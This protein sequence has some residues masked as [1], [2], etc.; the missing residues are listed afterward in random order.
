MIILSNI[1]DVYFTLF[2][3]H[4][5]DFGKVIKTLNGKGNIVETKIDLV[6]VFCYS[7]NEN[8]MFYW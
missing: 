5:G 3:M 4:L 6:H 2:I 1:N 7:I 8:L